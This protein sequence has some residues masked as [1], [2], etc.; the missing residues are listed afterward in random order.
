[1][2]EISIDV[3]KISARKTWGRNTAKKIRNSR[4]P[5]ATPSRR[6]GPMDATD[7]RLPRTFLTAVSFSDNIHLRLFS[8]VKN[9]FL[10][11]S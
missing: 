7:F 8:L 9:R 3:E 5:T 2:K 10:G 6:T 4:S 11:I 1:L